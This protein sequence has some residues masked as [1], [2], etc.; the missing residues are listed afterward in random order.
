V[1]R[2]GPIVEFDQVIG[3]VANNGKFQE[4]H[5]GQLQASIFELIQRPCS[6]T[7]APSLRQIDEVDSALAGFATRLTVFT[8]WPTEV[9]S[10]L[11][12]IILELG[13][14]SFNHK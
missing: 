8:I 12:P 4:T 3:N 1:I 14:Q 13:S 10:A 11:T 5:M 7:A 6:S 2:R 9:D